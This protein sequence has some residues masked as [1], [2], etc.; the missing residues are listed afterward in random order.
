M[1][2]QSRKNLTGEFFH[3]IVQGIN[4]ER[5]FESDKMKEAYK[6]L[7]RKNLKDTKIN[8]LAYCVMNNH[9][10]ILVHS[11]EKEQISIFMR[12]VNTGYAKLYNS[13]NVRV[14][15]VFRDRY[16]IQMIKNYTHLFRC[17]VYIHNNPVKAGLVNAFS[18]YKYSSY[19]EYIENKDLITEDGIKKIFGEKE[20][21]KELF[22][23]IHKLT[24][25]EDISDIKEKD[26]YSEIINTYI[27]KYNTTAEKIIQNEELFGNLL[28]KLRHECGLSLRDMAKIFKINKDKINK[29]LHKVL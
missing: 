10:H 15:Y 3:L 28:I 17:I 13:L 24:N 14:G 18:Q 27:K 12:K 25:I 19:N 23:S 20:N 9:V 1:P 16:Y 2:R 11:A 29:I 21:Y 22:N 6:S 4:K 8:I 26:S 7:L 5:I